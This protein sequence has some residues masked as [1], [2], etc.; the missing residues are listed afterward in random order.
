MQGIFSDRISDVPRSFIREILKV[1]ID[2][3]IISFAGGLPNRDLFPVEEIKKAAIR[4]LEE[5]GKRALQYG[6]SEGLFELRKYISERYMKK[7]HLEIP[8]ENILITNGSQQ[9]LDLLAKV[10][11]N[12]GDSVVVEE[13]GYLGALQTFSVYRARLIPVPVDEE[14]MDVGALKTTLLNEKIKLIYTVP[15]FQNPSGITYSDRNREEIAHLLR[16]KATIL[17]EDNPYGEL[18]FSGENKRSFRAI[19]PENAVLLGSFSKIVAP[20]V[21]LGWIVAPDFLMEKIITAKQA[22]DL[23]TNCLSQ[24]VVYQYL[25]DNDVD[26]HVKKIVEVYG[27]QRTM[28]LSSIKAHFPASVKSTEPDGGMFLWVT[29]PR[30][31]SAMKLFHESIKRKVAFVPGDPFYVNKT[32]VNTIRLNFSCSDEKTIEIG[33]RRLADVIKKNLRYL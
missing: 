18:R 13:P 9:A 5:D 15:N 1:A 24:R 3:T 27:R 32:D 23:H 26:L 19:I 7:Q 33:I 8:V 16:G 2:P 31:M 10:I 30:G 11:L 25:V 4:V 29:L 17:V 6:N 14:G 12:E 28:M 21:R 20:G 22:A